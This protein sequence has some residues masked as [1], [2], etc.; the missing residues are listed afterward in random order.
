MGVLL[1]FMDNE[2][3]ASSDTKLV[4]RSLNAGLTLLLLAL[5]VWRF[6]LEREIL[7]MRNVLP[8]HVS[9]FRL[10][11]QLLV[12]VVELLVCAVCVPP[13]V[14]GR[15]TV[16]E[17]KYYMDSRVTTGCV[18]PF[19]ADRGSCYMTYSYPYVWKDL[20]DMILSYKC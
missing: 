2:Y 18:A 4:V 20:F 6:V 8:P 13:G 7:V 1:V 5:V 12:L 9:V 11:R 16:W 10:P 15:F 19:H 3:A 14:D 17:W